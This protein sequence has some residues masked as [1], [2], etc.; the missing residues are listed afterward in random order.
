MYLCTMAQLLN[1]QERHNL[2]MNIVGKDLEAQ[3]FEFLGVNSQL[4]RNPQFV[5]LKDKKLH[6]VIVRALQ[7]PDDPNAYDP[8]FMQEMKSH[9]EKFNA[10]TFYAGVGLG[11]A[12]DYGQ[13]VEKVSA[14]TQVYNGLQEI[15]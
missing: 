7:Y 6:F 15:L 13:P 8:V 11:S 4:K 14:Y 3:G 9:A 12:E 2:A 5:A 1:E 10:R